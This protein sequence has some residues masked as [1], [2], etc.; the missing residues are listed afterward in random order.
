MRTRDATPADADAI[1]T[2]HYRAIEELGPRAYS[3]EQVDAWAEGCESADYVSAIEANEREFIVAELDGEVEAFGSLKLLPPDGY[4]AD[5]D[6]EVTGV[7]V[8]PS[9]VRR[10]VGTSVYSELERRARTHNVR[11]LGLSASLNAV[12]FYEARG[13][14][15]VREYTHEFSGHESTG[16]TGTVVEMKKEL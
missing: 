5:V 15:R 6:A 4:E 10:G 2:V 14:V 16:V 1:R 9:A 11:T 8:H 12:S 13:Y 3:R 7:Y